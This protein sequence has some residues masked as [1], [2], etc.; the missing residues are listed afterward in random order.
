[1]APHGRSRSEMPFFYFVPQIVTVVILGLNFI[2]FEL[3][4]SNS[5]NFLAV[6]HMK[7]TSVHVLFD[8]CEKWEF[9]WS[10]VFSD[11]LLDISS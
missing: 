4:I 5:G 1:M 3:S 10:T 2:D 7:L 8:R 9:N 11:I 6:Q